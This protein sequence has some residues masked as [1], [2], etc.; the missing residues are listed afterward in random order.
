[1][2]VVF[3]IGATGIDHIVT[4]AAYPSPDDKIR[5]QG[6]FVTYGGNCANTLTGELLKM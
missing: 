2:S 1:M 6:S 4:V 3:G 5:T